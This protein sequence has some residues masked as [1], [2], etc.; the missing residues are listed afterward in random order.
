VRYRSDDDDSARWDD[1]PFRDGDI[2]ISARSK[3]GTTWVQM[4]CTIADRLGIAVPEQSWPSLVEAAM[5][6][7]M[8]AEPDMME[9]LHR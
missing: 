6:A 4:I 5:F 8:R 1:L 7:N 9:W 3:T 2:V